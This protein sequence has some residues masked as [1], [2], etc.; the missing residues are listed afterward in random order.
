MK[1][2]KRHER[3]ERAMKEIWERHERD[4]RETSE[5]HQRDIRETS[6]RHKRDIRETWDKHERDFNFRTVHDWVL[7]GS[8][9]QPNAIREVVGK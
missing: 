6:E 7:S 8:I 2:S 3:Q 4:I 9:D 1:E 5:R